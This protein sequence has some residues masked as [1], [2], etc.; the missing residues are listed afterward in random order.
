MS[1]QTI[2]GDTSHYFLL[3]LLKREFQLFTHRNKHTNQIHKKLFVG[4]VHGSK[5]QYLQTKIFVLHGS[6][7]AHE[8]D[9]NTKHKIQKTIVIFN[10]YY[11]F[12]PNDCNE[13][14]NLNTA[15]C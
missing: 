7:K 1:K 8:Y 13:F 14:Q 4:S 6:T 15:F 10:I 3:D 12:F 9:T 2:Y 5:K 11:K